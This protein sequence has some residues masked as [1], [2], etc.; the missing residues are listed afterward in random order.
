VVSRR[1]NP[2]LSRRGSGGLRFANPTHGLVTTAAITVW[3]TMYEATM[4]SDRDIG[5]E[6]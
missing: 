6:K 4:K 3:L 1:R 5:Q 2:Q